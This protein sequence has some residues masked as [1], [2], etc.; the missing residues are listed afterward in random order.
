MLYVSARDRRLRKSPGEPDCPPLPT[1]LAPE[2]RSEHNRLNI[3]LV[4]LNAE[5]KFY[6]YF[7]II[8]QDPPTTPLPDDILNVMRLTLELVELLYWKPTLTMGSQGEVKFAKMV[9]ES[10]RNPPRR[11]RADISKTVERGSSEEMELEGDEGK[12]GFPAGMD[13]EARK[14]YGRALMSGPGVLPFHCHLHISSRLSRYLD[15][16]YD[17]TL[18]DNTIP[19]HNSGFFLHL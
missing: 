17:P 3:F 10:R 5:I 9:K 6:R 2:G 18:F 13:L 19:P 16:H 1:F 8:S 12:S 7:R 4:V 11:K 14:A 15:W